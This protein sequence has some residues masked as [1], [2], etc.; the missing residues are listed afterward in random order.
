MQDQKL[1]DKATECYNKILGLDNHYIEA[2]VNLGNLNREVNNLNKASFYF[3]KAL[4]INPK[5]EIAFHMHSALN[6]I[7]VSSSPKD[8]ITSLFD[9]YSSNFDNS[10]Q[11]IL[12]PVNVPSPPM[13]IK[14]STPCSLMLM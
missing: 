5:H 13:A 14:P 10:L 9:R 4:E 8:Y 1:Y 3:S 6:G 2:Y 12:A 7:S 11:N